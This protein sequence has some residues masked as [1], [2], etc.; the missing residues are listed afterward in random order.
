MTT[1]NT[2]ANIVRA[3]L[4]GSGTAGMSRIH[5]DRHDSNPPALNLILKRSATGDDDYQEYSREYRQGDIDRLGHR[6][7]VETPSVQGA[8]A[9][10]GRNVSKEQ[11]PRPVRIL[12]REGTIQRYGTPARTKASRCGGRAGCLPIRFPGPA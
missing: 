6:R 5:S 10:P 7:N 9:T 11:R 4:T 8:G 2:P 3:T 12:A 1:R